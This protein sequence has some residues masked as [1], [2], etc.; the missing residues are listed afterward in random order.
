MA[1]MLTEVKR[2]DARTVAFTADD[3]ILGFRKLR[4]L[5][6]LAPAR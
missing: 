2:V 6:A 4:A 1:A 5:I 3:F